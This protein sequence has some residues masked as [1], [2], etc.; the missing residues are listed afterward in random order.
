M[1]S[2]ED[3]STII[4]A[5]YPQ[6]LESANFAESTLPTPPSTTSSSTLPVDPNDTSIQR[7]VVDQEGSSSS[8]FSDRTIV[9]DETHDDV[10]LPDPRASMPDLNPQENSTEA[11]ELSG[12]ALWNIRQTLLPTTKPS[13]ESQGNSVVYDW[14]F[15]RSASIGT[16][17]IDP[18][19]EAAESWEFLFNPH[20]QHPVPLGGPQHELEY[21]KAGIVELLSQSDDTD[22]FTGS[23]QQ[24]PNRTLN[25]TSLYSLLEKKLAS[26]ELEYDGQASL[27]WWNIRSLFV[28]LTAGR[29]QDVFLD[30]LL[31]ELARE[32]QLLSRYC[33]SDAEEGESEVRSLSRLA[34]YSR[35][36]TSRQEQERRSLRI[37]LWYVCEVRHSSTH[38]EA[39]L[40]TQAL[41]A[42]KLLK[43]KTATNGTFKW[44]RQRLKTSF[45]QNRAVKQALEAVAAPSEFGDLSKLADHQI[46]MTSKWMAQDGIQNFCNGEE[47]IHKFCHQ[48]QRSVNRLVGPNFV[49]SPVLWSS[50]LFKR[51]KSAFMARP[52]RYSEMA[53]CMDLPRSTGTLSS[54]TGLRLSTSEPRLPNYSIPPPTDNSFLDAGFGHSKGLQYHIYTGESDHPFINNDHPNSDNSDKVGAST[55]SGRR[56][57]MF[58]ADGSCPQS[59]NDFLQSLKQSLFGLLSSDLGPS[60]SLEQSETDTWINRAIE[61]NEGDASPMVPVDPLTSSE[62]NRDETRPTYSENA[63]SI[64]SA[65]EDKSVPSGVPPSAQSARRDP[66]TTAFP[67]RHFYKTLF[68]RVSLTHDPTLKL[69]L[70]RELLDL[71][72]QDVTFSSE[73][74]S[75]SGGYQN[76]EDR[77][78]D[79]EMIGRRRNDPQVQVT[80]PGPSINDQEAQA[81]LR[82]GLANHILRQTSLEN[83]LQQIAV[84]DDDAVMQKLLSIIRD[85]DLRSSTLYKDLQLISAF[86]PA[87]TLNQTPPGKAFWSI[88]LAALALK[89]E[90]CSATIR[91]ATLITNAHIHSKTGLPSPGPSLQDAAQ[92]WVIAAKEGSVVA[93]RELG[94][95]YL[96]HPDLIPRTTKPFSKSQDVFRSAA[97]TD[98]SLY[99]TDTATENRES[100]ALDPLTFAVVFHWMEIAAGGGDEE[101]KAFLRQGQN[102]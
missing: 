43:R 16:V 42:M 95:F 38:E 55:S 77:F 57:I 36:H 41:H 96:T 80:A 60:S 17:S 18:L 26:A 67:F 4:Q 74:S 51:E 7:C 24:R 45:G 82:Q 1:L 22:T 12:K 2:A 90:L 102:M 78:A 40:V 62:I 10:C 83:S 20:T 34:K 79:I 5:L 25:M 52:S 66:M 81:Q 100:G 9:A 99:S 56:A 19:G 31:D 54:N 92:L 37:K 85:P 61:F 97:G 39:R 32:L 76:G 98:R 46:D 75:R 59:K 50:N 84:V 71:V 35:A 86:V 49:D 93:A 8:V 15:F 63:T 70:L 73:T 88:A 64:S 72:K 58:A 14:S 23:H 87:K 33:A 94:L 91:R 89:D 68:Q 11:C 44:A 101:A 48:I 3:I 30:D 29:D 65:S 28:R 53:N 13:M 47:K 21:L 27:Y 6:E 69:Q